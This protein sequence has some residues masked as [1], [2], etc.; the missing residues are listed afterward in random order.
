MDTETNPKF[1]LVLLL[2]LF[3]KSHISYGADSICMDDVISG[4]S[5][6]VSAG[7]IFEMGF[8]RP[9]SAPNYCIGIWYL[10][11]PTR[12]AVWVANRE[13]PVKLASQLRMSD[14]NLVLFD[15]SKLPIWST[16]VSSSSATTTTRSVQAVL[17]DTGNLF[18][19]DESSPSEPLWQ[20]FDYPSHTWLPGAKMGYSKINKTRQIL[21]SWKNSEDPD[22]GIFSLQLDQS[23]NSFVIQWNRSKNSWR[24]G[25]WD[26]HIFSGI[27][28]MR[29]DYVYFF[30][31]VSNKNETYITY[32]MKNTST[33]TCHFEMDVS[34]QINQVNWLPT[35]GWNLFW[36]LPA[37]QC[38]VYAVCG[39]YG[40]CKS[41]ENSLLFCHCLTG[42]EPN[43]PIDWKLKD[44]SGG[45]FRKTKLQCETNG[46][47]VELKSI[48]QLTIIHLSL[49]Y[50]KW[51]LPL[52]SEL[53]C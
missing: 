9:D 7:R 24:S 28:Q 18:L 35:N 37:Q 1:K 40:S 32:S 22:P 33:L 48:K 3:L 5:T 27:P 31:F 36:S 50:R 53:S 44:Y 49:K 8:F 25:P 45:C 43:S 42:F 41:N 39:A 46:S 26:G 10:K 12:R 34:G 23:D 11:D 14:G 29:V 13:K 51:T 30:S 21:T 38:E 19:N 2:C 15:E 16:N 47:S 17:L 20:S 4:D 6:I 52:C